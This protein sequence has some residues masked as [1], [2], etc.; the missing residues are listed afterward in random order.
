MQQWALFVL[1]SSYIIFRN[2]FLMSLLYKSEG[3]GFDYRW[4]HWNFSLTYSLRPHYG[5]GVDSTSNRNK[6]Q[7]CF[8]GVKA[9][10]AQGWQLYHFHVPI[11]LKSGNL[12]LLEPSG[13]VQACN[14]IALHFTLLISWR[15]AA[16]I[17]C[18]ILTKFGLSLT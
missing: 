1:S 16:G 18:P 13:P 9:A 2:A 3:R 8:L 5:P 15:K 11:V 10:G 7:E 6:Y 12:N 14:G 17:F 4:C